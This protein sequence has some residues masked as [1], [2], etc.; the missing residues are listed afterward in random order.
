MCV[1]PVE[2]SIQPETLS[3]S[4]KGEF[5]ALITV[6]E[7]FNVR[8]WGVSNVVCEGAPPV[9]GTVTDGGRTYTAEFKVSGLEGVTPGKQKF[10]VKGIFQHNRGTP[11]FQGRAPV[12]VTE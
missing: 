1:P 8:D 2:V 7:G 10:T 11:Q 3:L 12:T 5:R 6:P 4:S 9:K